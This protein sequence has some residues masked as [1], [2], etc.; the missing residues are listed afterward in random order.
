MCLLVSLRPIAV[1]FLSLPLLVGTFMW[2]E[3]IFRSKY[4][5]NHTPR[6]FRPKLKI[7]DS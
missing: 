4:K 6:G 3:Q 7:A 5:W 1:L 2:D